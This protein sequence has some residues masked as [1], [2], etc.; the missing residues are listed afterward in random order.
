MYAQH[1]DWF[2]DADEEDDEDA[3]GS[4]LGGQNNLLAKVKYLCVYACVFLLL[5]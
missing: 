4:G 2:E 1:W 3:K 5:F